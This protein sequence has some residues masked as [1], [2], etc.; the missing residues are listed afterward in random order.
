MA[1]F[2]G[3]Y[4][5]PVG[6][7]AIVAAR[8]NRLVTDALLSGCLDTLKRHGVSEDRIDVFWVPG[9]FEV[10]MVARKLAGRGDHLAIICLGCVVRGETPH[11]DHVAGQAAAGL[12]QVSLTTGV[13][14]IFGILTTDS[15]DQALNRAGLKSGNKG[16]DAALA[17][18]EMVNLLARLE[19]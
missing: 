14:I 18:I 16:S 4:S 8:F 9:S 10:P 13:P 6:R 5:Q 1:E 19:H 2:I 12:M 11:F 7:L 3:D 17:A 15:V